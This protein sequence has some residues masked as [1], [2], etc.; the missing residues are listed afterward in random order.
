MSLETL[1][2]EAAALDETARRELRAF[3]ISLREEQW[4]SHLRKLG[5]RLND[6]DPNRWLTLEELRERLDRIP[7]P[8][9]E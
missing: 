4:A 2:R 6:P 1:K 8:A 9:E 5:A 7:E 3:L